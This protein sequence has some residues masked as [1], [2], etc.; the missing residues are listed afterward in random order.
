[1][2]T[3]RSEPKIRKRTRKKAVP[4][5]RES[6]DKT[7]NPE[8]AKLRMVLSMVAENRSQKEIADHFGCDVRTVRR[9]IKKA[10]E[11]QLAVYQEFNPEEE[12]AATLF[13]LGELRAEA[14][15]VG[16]A[17]VEAGDSK[18]VLRTVEQ[19]RRILESRVAILTKLGHFDGYRF[20]PGSAKIGRDNTRSP[21]IDAAF[22]VFA[23]KSNDNDD[24]DDS[25][26]DDVEE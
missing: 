8:A 14:A 21:V 7:E 23:S 16:R 12:I 2:S 10:R 1:M 18:L 22:N 13:D 15:S 24:P 9:W 4:S 11:Q 19:R 3:P 25:G 5:S 17:A 26:F 20:E 6:R